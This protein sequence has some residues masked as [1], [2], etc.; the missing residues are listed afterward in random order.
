MMSI[1]LNDVAILKIT[2]YDCCRIVSFI[3]KYDTI[4]LMQNTGLTE[5]SRRFYSTKIYYHIQK[6]VKKFYHLGIL[7]LKTIKFNTIKVLCH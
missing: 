1:N 7:K 2:G 6:W 5:K 4:N 3:S